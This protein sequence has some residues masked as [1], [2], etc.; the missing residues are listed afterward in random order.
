MDTDKQNS[1]SSDDLD[2]GMTTEGWTEWNPELEPATMVVVE[3]KDNGE[4][5]IIHFTIT[6]NKD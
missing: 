6:V 4:V 2:D 5:S 3:V 1:V